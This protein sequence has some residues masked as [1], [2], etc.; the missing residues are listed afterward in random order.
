MRTTVRLFV[1]ILWP[2]QHHLISDLVVWD[3]FLFSFRLFFLM[4]F[5]LAWPDVFPVRGVL[6]T[7]SCLF[8]TLVVLGLLQ[9]CVIRWSHCKSCGAVPFPLRLG[10]CLVARRYGWYSQWL[11]EFFPASICLWVLTDGLSLDAIVILE[12][13]LKVM[14][15]E[16]ASR[17]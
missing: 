3:T 8:Q 17:S 1:I 16:F 6:V 7:K 14:S 15:Y 12:H 11:G 5:L 2:L 13:V 10:S 4:S 9:R